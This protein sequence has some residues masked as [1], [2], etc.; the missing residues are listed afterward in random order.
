MIKITIH[1]KPYPSPRPRFRNVG[2]YKQT[3]MPAEYLREKK[4]IADSMEKIKP[5][6]FK[7]IESAIEMNVVFYMPIP[8]SLSDKKRLEL[9][10][11]PHIKKPDSD[12]LLKTYKDAFEGVL[13]KNDSQIYKV[14]I[15]K[16]YSDNPRVE[17]ELKEVF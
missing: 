11:E 10:G 12:N 2:K 15:L 16:I 1:R 8:A 7:I 5:N 9:V 6:D 17:I 4:I 13:Y 3:Y 14:D